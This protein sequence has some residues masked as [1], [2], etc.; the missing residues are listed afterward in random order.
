MSVEKKKY[1]FVLKVVFFTAVY[2]VLAVTIGWGLQVY[3]GEPFA[4]P[5]SQQ[6]QDYA[7]IGVCISV[8]M[9]F[10]S[11]NRRRT[12]PGKGR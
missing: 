9:Q 11:R 8:A 4:W 6:W 1:P 2:V 12:M 5:T 10:L 7:S 3:H